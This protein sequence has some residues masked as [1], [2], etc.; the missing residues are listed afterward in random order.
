MGSTP[1]RRRTVRASG[2]SRAAALVALVLCSSLAIA[3]A[4][5]EDE[6]SSPTDGAASDAVSEPIDADF[7]AYDPTE[8]FA[9]EEPDDGWKRTSEDE[10]PRVAF[11]IIDVAAGIAD[12]EGSGDGQI[13]DKAKRQDYQDLAAFYHAQSATIASFNGREDLHPD[14][15]CEREI[16]QLCGSDDMDDSHVTKIEFTKTTG[17]RDDASSDDSSDASSAAVTERRARR[18]LLADPEPDPW[19][20]D[21]DDPEAEMTEKD[22]RIRDLEDKV[23]ALA[24][25]IENVKGGAADV[26]LYTARLAM[27]VEA[28]AR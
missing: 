23:N 18:A 4:R 16:K 2:A 17:H 15:A 24:G 1:G 19:G 9:F 21:E 26:L 11:E 6:S 10:M 3:G 28:F 12:R 13:K 25:L 5:A 8:H 20:V 22:R 14:G 7:E 27:R